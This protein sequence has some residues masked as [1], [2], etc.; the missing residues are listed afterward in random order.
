L[1]FTHGGISNIAT[2]TKRTAYR[3]FTAGARDVDVAEARVD[4]IWVYARISVNRDALGSEALGVGGH[5][6]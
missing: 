5:E 3:G 6:A 4:Q 1:Q 2:A